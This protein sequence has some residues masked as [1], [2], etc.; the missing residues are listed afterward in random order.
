MTL[1]SFSDKTNAKSPSMG[2]GKALFNF[3]MKNESQQD[4][5][6]VQSQNPF[7]DVMDETPESERRGTRRRRGDRGMK[8]LDLR[9]VGT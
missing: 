1:P 9:N 5:Q 2:V 7:N 3:F 4:A 6:S 8:N